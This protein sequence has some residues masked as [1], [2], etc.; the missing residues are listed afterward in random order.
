MRS[1]ASRR[2]IGETLPGTA[3]S[4]GTLSQAVT[5][6]ACGNKPKRDAL[7]S[8][9][10]GSP[11]TAYGLRMPAGCGSPNVLS[12]R[13]ELYREDIRHARLGRTD[14]AVFWFATCGPR[15]AA[16]MFSNG[17][18]RDAGT[19]PNPPATHGTRASLTGCPH[20]GLL[21]ALEFRPEG[22]QIPL[23]SPAVINRK[24]LIVA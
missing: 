3:P 14:A 10:Y 9:T 12:R 2:R 7:A 1:H 13:Q 20:S 5:G 24:P 19:W 23:E 4:P 8:G 17:H 15:S 21:P 18:S 22:L 11:L 16:L 6:L